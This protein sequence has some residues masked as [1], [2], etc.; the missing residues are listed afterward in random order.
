MTPELHALAE[1]V[2]TPDEMSE[3]CFMWII[4]VFNGLHEN[5]IIRGLQKREQLKSKGTSD[6]NPRTPRTVPDSQEK[7]EDG[8]CLDR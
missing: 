7:K 1:E 3:F 4:G 5:F 2:L 8:T 6:A